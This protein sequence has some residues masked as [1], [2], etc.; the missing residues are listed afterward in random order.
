M[1]GRYTHVHTYTHEPMAAIL[2]IG[3]SWRELIHAHSRRT[4]VC[5]LLYGVSSKIDSGGKVFD[6]RTF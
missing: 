4:H 5:L 3:A 2:W 1:L 6:G